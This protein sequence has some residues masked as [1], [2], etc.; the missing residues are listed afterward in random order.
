ML[1]IRDEI[2]LKELEKFDYKKGIVY[3]FGECYVKELEYNDFI[4][5]KDDKTILFETP[6]F[7]IKEE[8]LI[9]DLI[10]AG[11]VEKIEE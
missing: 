10:K 5:I 4:F 9:D 7:R 1:K 2:D 6:N 8:I 11:L 3:C